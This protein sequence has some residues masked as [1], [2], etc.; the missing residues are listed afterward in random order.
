M[1]YGP[2]CSLFLGLRRRS[3]PLGRGLAVLSH[4][5]QRGSP[6]PRV[7]LS[8]PSLSLRGGCRNVRLLCIGV[9]VWVDLSS[10]LTLGRLALP[11]KPCPCGV[12]V[13]RPHCRYLCLHLLFRTLHLGSRHGFA[14]SGM[15]PYRYYVSR[16]FGSALDA[17]L[18]SARCRSTSELL[19]TLQMG[20]C[21]QANILAVT[22]AAPLL[23]N[24]GRNWGP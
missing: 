3:Y 15:L 10:R 20:G 21:F 2:P 11:R 1:R 24:L 8:R 6:S 5:L 16:A 22:A 18:S 4:A 13:S 23:I 12:R 17:R 9:P 14:A 19:R 7:R